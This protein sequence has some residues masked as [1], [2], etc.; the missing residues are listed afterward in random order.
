MTQPKIGVQMMMLKQK[1]EEIGV[2]ETLKELM[3]L[4]YRSVEVSQIPMTTE[5]VAELKRGSTDFSINI[6]ALSAPVEPMAP[7]VQM[8]NLT[9]NFDKII[10]DCQELNCSYLRIGMLPVHIMGD[11]EK[12]MAF[13]HRAEA[14]AERLAARGIQ[15]YYHTHHIEFQKYNGEYLLDLMKNNTKTLGF[16]LDVHWIQRAGEDP[17][18]MIQQYRG[19]VS[20]LHLKDYRIGQVDASEEALKDMRAFFDGFT[21][22][23]E[24]AELGEGNLDLKAIIEAGLEAGVEH[25]F[26]E[27]DDTYGRNPFECLKFLE[28]T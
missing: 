20:L 13:I 26:I 14:L 12:I 6:A 19:R 7:G 21:N 23:I 5:N 4:G 24:F 28:I 2:Y 8:E 18:K 10:G 11:K 22:L 1:A 3:N 16:E 25:F 9:D 17:I 15:L 27:Q